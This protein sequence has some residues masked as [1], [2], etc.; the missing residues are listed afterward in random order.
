MSYCS[1]SS[2]EV[3]NHRPQ[4]TKRPSG[5]GSGPEGLFWEEVQM[6]REG[7]DPGK[8]L[9]YSSNSTPKSVA[10]TLNRKSSHGFSVALALL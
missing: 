1:T 3:C 7:P 6:E 4:D 2:E 8:E 5:L 9:D 10:K